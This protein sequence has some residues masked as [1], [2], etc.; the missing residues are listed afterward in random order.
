MAESGRSWGGDEMRLIQLSCGVKKYAARVEEG[1]FEGHQR[2]VDQC[3][4]NKWTYLH[5][6]SC[7]ILCKVDEVCV[8]DDGRDGMEWN[9]CCDD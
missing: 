4:E 8:E 6:P 9:G 3:E 7:R 5:H 1:C 2:L